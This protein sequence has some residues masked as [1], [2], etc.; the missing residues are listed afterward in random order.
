[1]LAVFEDRRVL[2]QAAIHGTASE[3]MT[4]VREEVGSED[5][6]PLN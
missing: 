3:T 1:M 5:P 6:H 2:L 4:W